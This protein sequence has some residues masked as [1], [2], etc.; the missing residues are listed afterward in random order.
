[1]GKDAARMDVVI[2]SSGWFLLEMGPSVGGALRQPTAV[3]PP[4][5]RG[6]RQL[7]RPVLQSKFGMALD[8]FA[9]LTRGCGLGF[10]PAVAPVS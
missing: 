9:P 10:P 4:S 7:L 1:M 5:L 6:A 2:F 3:L 8:R